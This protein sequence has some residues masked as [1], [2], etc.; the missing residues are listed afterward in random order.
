MVRKRRTSNGNEVCVGGLRNPGQAPR[1]NSRLAGAG[2]V[3]RSIPEGFINKHPEF[4]G[5][6]DGGEGAA[7]L[8][9]QPLDALRR[10]PLD[11]W[12][13]YTKKEAGSE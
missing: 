12:E 7:E 1:Y 5:L 6:A 11:A 2:L 8:A 10:Q 3:S 4:L 13:V 9:K